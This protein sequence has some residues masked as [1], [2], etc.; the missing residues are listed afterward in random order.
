[1]VYITDAFE[2]SSRL[3][4]IWSNYLQAIVALWDLI[5]KKL[6]GDMSPKSPEIPVKMMMA[7]LYFHCIH[8]CCWILGCGVLS[9]EDNTIVQRWCSDSNDAPVINIYEIMIKDNLRYY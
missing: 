8:S 5:I 7:G 1:M 3:E 2:S 9:D 6:I 4:V